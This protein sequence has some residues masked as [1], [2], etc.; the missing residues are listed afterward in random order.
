MGTSENGRLDYEAGQSIQE[1]VALTDD[2]DH[3]IFNSAD[4]FW[5]NKAGKA[6][7]VRPNGLLSGG[8]VTPGISGSNDKIDVA[9]LKCYLAGVLTSVAASAD[10]DITR[11]LTTDTH[12]I[13]SVTVT[14]AGAIA[15]IAGTDHTAFSATRGAAGG[16]PWIPTGSIEIAQIKLTSIAAA[17]VTA[18]EICDVPNT[19]QERADYPVWNEKRINIVNQVVGYAGIEFVSALP[20]IHSDDAGSTTAGKKVYAEYNT[21]EFAEIPDAENFVPPKNTHSVNSKQVYGR[22][23]GSSSSSLGQG[24]FTFYPKDGVTDPVL[25]EEDEI[26]MFRFFPDRLKPEYYI[27]QGKFGVAQTF[28]AGDAMAAN[29]TISAEEKA[30]GV[31]N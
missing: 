12:I 22:T 27:T 23:I 25:K 2:G 14:S 24:S 18:A 21:P 17:V 15:I 29:C 19:H 31:A 9:A 6:P 5:S 11:G 3:K 28:P 20:Q 8:A 7:I 16:P 4:N 30:Q 1:F 26:I 10:E 13:N